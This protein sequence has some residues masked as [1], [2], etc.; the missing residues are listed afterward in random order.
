M[1]IMGL[2]DNVIDHYTNLQ[3][4][5]PGGNAVNVAAHGAMLGQQAA[6]LGNLGEDKLSELIRSSLNKAG[7]D[8]SHCITVPEGT[9]KCCNYEVIDGERFLV[10]I[11]LGEKWS[12]PMIIGNK[13]LEYMKDFDVIHS[14]CN[15]KMEYEI[16]KLG[17]LDAIITYDFSTKEKYRTPEYLY[18]VGPYL[19]LALFSCDGY[20]EDQAIQLAEYI[21]EY[22]PKH[23]LITAGSQGQYLFNGTQWIKGEMLYRKPVDTMGAGDSFLTALLVSLYEH[24]WRKGKSMEEAAMTAAL[25]IAAQYSAEN[26]MT[27]GG[28]HL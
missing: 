19:D 1:K 14:C 23:V 7:V 13:Q 15:A 27:A 21:M 18:K 8:I 20:S 26:C 5:Y 28:F 16:Y 4:M 11:E 9:T 25:Q 22:G 3:V 12:G 10:G 24:G 17:I 6:Y 2:G